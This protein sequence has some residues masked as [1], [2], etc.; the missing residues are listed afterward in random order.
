LLFLL[1]FDLDDVDLVFK[2]FKQVLWNSGILLDKWRKKMMDM[3]SN[4]RPGISTDQ[5]NRQ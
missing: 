5:L 1:T 2:G 3:A 4:A